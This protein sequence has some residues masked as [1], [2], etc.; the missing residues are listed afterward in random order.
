MLNLTINTK[1]NQG[2]EAIEIELPMEEMELRNILS[3]TAEEL[4]EE[5]PE[6]V[7]EGYEWDCSEVFMVY[8]NDNI[9]ELNRFT[10]EADDMSDVELCIVSAIING[11]ECGNPIEEAIDHIGNYDIEFGTH[12]GEGKEEAYETDGAFGIIGAVYPIKK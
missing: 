4:G 5:N 2:N 1:A 11:F 12:A 7:I 10:K 3:R 8:D 9:F 6:W